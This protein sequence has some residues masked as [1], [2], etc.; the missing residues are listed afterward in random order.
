MTT[1]KTP[2]SAD[3]QLQVNGTYKVVIDNEPVG[4]EHV[5]E[6]LAKAYLE[7]VLKGDTDNKK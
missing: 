2:T 3:I 1:K 6:Q 4:P 7:Q 5:N